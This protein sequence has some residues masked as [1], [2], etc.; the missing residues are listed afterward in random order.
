MRPRKIRDAFAA[1]DDQLLTVPLDV[2]RPEQSQT[3]VGAALETFGRID[4]LVNNAG[5]GQLGYFEEQAPA[6]IEQ[7]FATNVFGAMHVTRAILPVMRRQRSGRIFN[8]SSVAGIRGHGWASIYCASKWALEGFTESL[9]QEVEPF[10]IR[11]T[12][13]CP[14]YFRTDFL[15]DS[16]IHYGEREVADYAEESRQMRAFFGSRNHRQAGDPEKLGRIVVRLAGA[17]H[18]PLRFAAGT[19]ATQM[20]E[21]KIACFREEL[22]EWRELSVTTDFA[23]EPAVIS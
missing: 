8:I 13:I 12:I 16:S 23:P 22:E 20:F 17:E 2:T 9:A 4:V 14:G 3:A 18:P 15:D 21:D 19:D 1:G 11:A 5:Y 6:T 10:G 7:Q